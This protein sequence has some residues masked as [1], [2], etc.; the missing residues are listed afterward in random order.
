[1]EFKQKAYC[2]IN[3]RAAGHPTEESLTQRRFNQRNDRA[4]VFSS[5]CTWDRKNPGSRSFLNTASE[6]TQAALAMGHQDP[7]GPIQEFETPSTFQKGLYIYIIY[8]N[9]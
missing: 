8:K 1:M 9:V 7:F 3:Q 5:L 2:I 4:S 6:E